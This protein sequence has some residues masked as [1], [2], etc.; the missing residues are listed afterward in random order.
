MKKALELLNQAR[1]EAIKNKYKKI[2]DI[3]SVTIVKISVEA[4]DVKEES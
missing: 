3:L 4:Y 2:E 1:E